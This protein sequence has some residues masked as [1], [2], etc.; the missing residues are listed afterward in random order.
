M[1]M[2]NAKFWPLT[3]L[4]LNLGGRQSIRCWRQGLRQVVAQLEI[5]QRASTWIW[6]LKSEQFQLLTGELGGESLTALT[7]ALVERTEPHMVSDASMPPAPRLPAHLLEQYQRLVT[8]PA[9]DRSPT[10]SSERADLRRQ[11]KG[12]YLE[13]GFETRAPVSLEKIK[14]L[15]QQ[16]PQ[17][18]LRQWAGTL[19]VQSSLGKLQPLKRP[20]AV[21]AKVISPPSAVQTQDAYNDWRQRLIQRVQRLL[22]SLNWAASSQSSLTTG[23]PLSAPS[24]PH[25]QESSLM[26]GGGLAEQWNNSLTG[27][28]LP[29]D[30]LRYLAGSMG[31][32]F[33]NR[34]SPSRPSATAPAAENATGSPQRASFIGQEKPVRQVVHPLTLSE[35]QATP[36]LLNRLSGNAAA[37]RA[38]ASAPLHQGQ[39]PSSSAMVPAVG[40]ATSSPQRA[41]LTGQEKPVRQVAHPLTLSE[42]Q[43]TQALLNRL[44]GNA[45]A[46]RGATSAPLH[47]GQKPSSSA[48]VPAVGDAT[49]SLQGAPFTGKEKP[50]SQATHP[51]TLSEK[52]T[53]QALLNHLSEDVAAEESSDSFATARKR[54]QYPVPT[55]PTRSMRDAEVIDHK[56]TASSQEKVAVPL[57]D[58]PQKQANRKL[59]NHLASKGETIFPSGAPFSNTRENR[60]GVSSVQSSSHGLSQGGH[61]EWPQGLSRAVAAFSRLNTFDQRTDLPQDWGEILIPNPE[62]LA[63]PLLMPDQLIDRES[64]E[65]WQSELLSSEPS[66][67]EIQ[68]PDSDMRSH[69]TGP[70]FPQRQPSRPTSLTPLHSAQQQLSAQFSDWPEQKTREGRRQ[71]MRDRMTSEPSVLDMPTRVPGQSQS[72]NYPAGAQAYPPPRI[73]PPAVASA[74][75]ALRPPQQAYEPVTPVAAST[76]RHGAQQEESKTPPAE[77]DELAVKIK[78]ILDEEAR[79]YGID[80]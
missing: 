4:K 39:K 32:E 27:P 55:V 66:P 53:P 52:Q 35:K 42:K 15:T 11:H 28:M 61:A 80:V 25:S 41:S 16:I 12:F 65:V 54:R 6:S 76:A 22:Q 59:L 44:S 48:M 30:W 56:G 26:M 38:A 37:E 33:P 75:P 46:E 24:L 64:S 14:T 69:T 19:P 9:G 77:L 13:G 49:G 70:S 18:R 67:K 71:Q 60:S 63:E 29:L 51:L 73:A 57:M 7:Q 17:T 58:L 45:A 23:I 79:R 47:Q 43:V 8:I 40:D 21:K 2:L 72:V 78:R 20:S 74:L 31:L 62:T 10:S 68:V 36:T 34:Q 50:M 3:V 5:L 1:A